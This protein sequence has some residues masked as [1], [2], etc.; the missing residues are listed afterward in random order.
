MLSWVAALLALGVLAPTGAAIAPPSSGLRQVIVL[1]RHG[2]RGPYGLGT[3]APSEELLKKYVR[4][5]NL[6]LPLSANA[7]GTSETEDPTE[8]VSPK[9]T[10]HGFQVIQRM[11]EYFRDHLYQ[12]FLNATCKETFAYADDNQRDNL[13]AI[14]FMSGLYPSCKDLVPITKQTQLLFEQGQ[15]PT[16]NCPVCSKAVYEGIVGSND[17]RFVLQEVHEEV[18]E[19][20]E[21]LQCCAHSV[22]NLGDELNTPDRSDR[23]NTCDLFEIPTTWNGAFYLPWKDTLSNADYFSEWLLLQSLNNMT[24][25]SQL[26]FEKIL[27]LAKIHSVTFRLSCAY[28]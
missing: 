20:N 1:S 9:L 3:E 2:V 18:A 27:S 10:K 8:T 12:E 19:V 28:L 4:N 6:D 17:T 22:C 11:G 13:T 16:A 25:P 5:P 24:L 23:S 26:T 15:N 7:W 21:L 14:A